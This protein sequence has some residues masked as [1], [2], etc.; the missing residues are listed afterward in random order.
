[1]G[2]VL[3]LVPTETDSRLSLDNLRSAIRDR[4]ITDARRQGVAGESALSRWRF[5]SSY[6]KEVPELAI[7]HGLLRYLDGA[8]IF[9]AAIDS[10]R[11]PARWRRIEKQSSIL[12]EKCWWA[13]IAPAAL[14]GGDSII[15]SL[16]KGRAAPFDGVRST[17]S[18]D[19]KRRCGL[20]QAG[21][22]RPVHVS[23]RFQDHRRTRSCWR[24]NL[25]NFRHPRRAQ[26]STPTWCS[27]GLSGRVC[28]SQTS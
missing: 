15:S 2:L 28:R 27:F 21:F 10:K 22:S 8:R 7:K 1:M 12:R 9:N 13:P 20:R 3:H 23:W 18:I 5:L 17:A 19:R 26:S 6:F 11:T 14:E 25:R 16:S 24:R 4:A